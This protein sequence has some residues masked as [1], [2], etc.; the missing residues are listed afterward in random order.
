M[1][2]RRSLPNCRARE[3]LD[4]CS[5]D[6]AAAGGHGGDPP[7]VAGSLNSSSRLFS[8]RIQRPMLAMPPLPGSPPRQEPPAPMHIRTRYR[9]S[10]VPMPIIAICFGCMAVVVA[11]LA[12]PP[13]KRLLNEQLGVLPWIVMVVAVLA[14]VAFLSWYTLTFA[15]VR[16]GRFRIHSM[17]GSRRIDLRRLVTVDVHAKSGSS[18]KR[19]RHELILRLVDEHGQEAWLPLNVWGDE[20]LLMA[21]LLRATVERKVRIEGEPMLVKRF[22]GLLDTYK[23]WDRQQAAA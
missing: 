23:S 14:P 13:A 22:S 21:R 8:V 12:F 18:S 5:I 20:D 16:R 3:R 19:R 7:D 6:D 15:E 10:A 11:L 2:N 9:L 4:M 1:L 17:G